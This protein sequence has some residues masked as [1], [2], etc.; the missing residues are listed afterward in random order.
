MVGGFW[1]SKE[2]EVIKKV[3]PKE[4]PVETVY[5]KEFL[6]GLSLKELKEIGAKFGTTDRSKDKLIAEILKLQSKK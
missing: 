2:P 3:Y 6:E 5:T 1:Y 4:K